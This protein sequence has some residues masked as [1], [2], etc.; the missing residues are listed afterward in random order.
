MTFAELALERYSAR[1]FRPEPVEREKL[2][3]IM[4]TANCAPTATNAQPFHI[5][6]VVSED[7]V[8]KVNEATDCGFGAPVMLV[9]G[10]APDRAWVRKEDGH[11]F[12]DVDAG[13]VGTHILFA[14]H[15]LGLATTW[16]GHLD[17]KRLLELF[18]EM[19]GY[20]I[21]AIFPIGYPADTKAGRPS[22]RHRK[23]KPI[24]EMTD[25]I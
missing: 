17:Q 16:V 10:A 15:A 20:E 4:E 11:N 24:E 9:L 12:A 22:E 1:A 23:R 18:P 14:V 19:R 3:E 5:W 8:K 25:Y 2:L 13:I 6:A 7:G 21:V